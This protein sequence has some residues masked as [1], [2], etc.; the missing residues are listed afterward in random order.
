M[1]MPEKKT[2]AAERL[3][4]IPKVDAV[5][6]HPVAQPLIAEAGRELFSGCLD[7]VF[8]DLRARIKAGGDAALD[9]PSILASV[10]ERL[11]ARRA[12]RLCRVI[13]ATGVILHTGLGR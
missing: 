6:A 13:N 8:D 2:P 11:S 3:R 1:T 4:K 10:R 5:L 9:V 12:P 7:Q